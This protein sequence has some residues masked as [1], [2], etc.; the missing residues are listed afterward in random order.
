MYNE[1]LGLVDITVS[2][3]K[4]IS[5]YRKC[6]NVCS[7][8][9]Y[10]DKSSV[11]RS[12]KAV[13]KMYQIVQAA[14]NEG[15]ETVTEL[16]ALLNEPDCAKWLAHQLVERAAITKEIRNKCFAIVKTLAKGES[17]EALGERMWLKEHSRS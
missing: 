1:T 16:A 4:M 7:L 9:D 5:E 13:G 14:N 12:N 2:G 17:A 11:K 6:A 3:K 10:A 8:I 15:P